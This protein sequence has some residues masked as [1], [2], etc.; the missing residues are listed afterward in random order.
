MAGE[1][2]GGGGNVPTFFSI[3]PHHLCDRQKFSLDQGLSG[4]STVISSVV[5][6]HQL[7][8]IL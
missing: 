4:F 2:L 1:R 7:T 3:P 6:S 5:V 8:A